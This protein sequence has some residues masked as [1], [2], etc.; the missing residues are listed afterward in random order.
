MDIPLTVQ[1]MMPAV[2]PKQWKSGTVMHILSCGV[3]LMEPAIAM[4]LFTRL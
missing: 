2:I 1:A 3:H 4:A